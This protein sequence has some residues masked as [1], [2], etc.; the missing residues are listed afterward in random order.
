MNSINAAQKFDENLG[1]ALS[2]RPGCCHD[3]ADAALAA[4]Q[5][6]DELC[7]RGTGLDPKAN[8]IALGDDAAVLTAQ[9]AHH[10]HPACT[11]HHVMR[12]LCA[13]RRI[14]RGRG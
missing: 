13:R 12:A 6:L 8:E 9:A 1:P 11:L 10:D 4:A 7:H 14:D 3:A 5:A 2:L